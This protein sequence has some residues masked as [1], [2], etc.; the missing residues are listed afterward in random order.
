M[1]Q[2]KVRAQDQQHIAQLHVLSRGCG[3]S[4]SIVRIKPL[5]QITR[6]ASI[7][8][9]FNWEARKAEFS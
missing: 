5:V 3:A 7:H 4:Q 9:R 2:L 8:R 1:S 6:K